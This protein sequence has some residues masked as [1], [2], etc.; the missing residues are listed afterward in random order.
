MARDH[1]THLQHS[2]IIKKHIVMS[3]DYAHEG[4]CEMSL[5]T[6]ADAFFPFCMQHLGH[7]TRSYVQFYLQ[8]ALLVLPLLDNIYFQSFIH[9]G[10]GTLNV[11]SLQPQNETKSILPGSHGFSPFLKCFKRC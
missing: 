5:A 6:L 3:N 2:T 11:Q 10:Y 9:Y 8:K 4:I 1:E 7:L